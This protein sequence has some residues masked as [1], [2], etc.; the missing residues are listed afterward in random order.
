MK[1]SWHEAIRSKTSWHEAIRSKT[2][3]HEAIRSKTSWLGILIMCESGVTCL[4]A[5]CCFNDHG[6]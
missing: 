5:D 1:T 3:W 4:T 6:A 2:S